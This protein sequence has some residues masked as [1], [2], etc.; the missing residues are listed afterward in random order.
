[1]SPNPKPLGAGYETRIERIF[2]APR[3]LVFD[4]FVDPKH[5]AAW[6]GPLACRNEILELDARPGGELRLRMAGPGYDHVM[7]GEYVQIDRPGRLVFKTKAFEAPDGGWG[8]ILNNTLTFDDIGG[9]TRML[10]QVRVERAEGELVMGALGG[11]RAGWGQSLERLG[12]LVGGGGKTDIDVGD[13]RVTLVRAFDLPRDK[14]WPYLIDPDLMTTWW[15]AGTGTVETMDVRPGGEWKVRTAHGDGESNLFWGRFVEIEPPSRLV[16]TQG[17][18]EHDAVP[19]ETTLSEE[20]G[21]TVLTRTMTFPSNA[22]RDGMMGS[23][24]ARHS[25]LSFDMLARAAA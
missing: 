22:Y 16:M 1:M 10:L 13:C 21:R 23:S 18:N 15:I 24:Y 12:D 20:W 6:W 11:M 17:F 19:V 4:C 3:E 25:A 8:I 7:G 9:A 2:E 5:L 14:L